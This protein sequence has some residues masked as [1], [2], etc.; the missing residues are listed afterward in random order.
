MNNWTMRCPRSVL[1]SGGASPMPCSKV[2]TIPHNCC[3]CITEKIM[4]PWIRWLN[5]VHLVRIAG[6]H[7]LYLLW[8]S[9]IQ[10][11]SIRYP[12][13]VVLVKLKKLWDCELGDWTKSTS[14]GLVEHI[15]YLLWE[16]WI[17]I[18]I[19]CRRRTIDVGTHIGFCHGSRFSFIAGGGR[20]M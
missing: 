9:W 11:F 10:I 1:V 4:R 12:I 20:L 7:L 15:F 5:Q 14:W 6:T 19:Y 2:H 18:F 17:Q 13:T 8:E 16:S 3:R